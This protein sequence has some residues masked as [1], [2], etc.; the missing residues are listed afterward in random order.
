[1]NGINK[2]IIQ[3]IRPY[4]DSRLLIIGILGF[5]CGTPLLLTSSTLA[6][7]LKEF[8]LTNATIGLFGFL[9]LP[10]SLR[11]IWA[12]L[13]DRMPIPYLTKRFGRRR[14]W[15]LA[16]QTVL[17]L[18]LTGFTQVDIK[19]QLF[20]TSIL[21]MILS[22][23]S[24]THWTVMIA[25]QV[26]SFKRKQY[27]PAEGVNIL[28]YRMGMV[29]SSAGALYLAQIVSWEFA[30]GTM[31][32]CIAL[33]FITT[34]IIDEPI[35]IKNDQAL[36]QEKKINSYLLKHRK[37]NPKFC[38]MLSWIYAA[39]IC[40]FLNFTK[41]PNWLLLLTLMFLYKFG[42][43]LIGSMS[44]LFYMELGFSKIDI[45]NAAKLFGM[46]ASIFG[47]LIGGALIIRWGFMKSIYINAI[48]HMFATLLYIALA[49]AGNDMFMLYLSI[50]IEHIT[51][52]MRTTALLSFQLTLCTPTYAATQLALMTSF[53]SL[54]R[55]LFS[56]ISG[57]LAT[58]LGWV[59]FFIL[60][61][62]ASIPA[63]L[64]VR[65]LMKENKKQN[66]NDI[67]ENTKEELAKAA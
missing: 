16:S 20:M 23:A 40:P 36:I 49:Y 32:I 7:W 57:I 24:A 9:S 45:A 55:S 8:G 30:Y 54:G 48:L 44:N 17:M 28:G 19:S 59:N 38:K 6:I 66:I 50:A 15:L 47:G 29:A 27:G 37:H 25:Y 5:T 26:E 65:H 60:A 34:L 13:V 52:G 58:T 18:T 12:P 22:F 61:T 67:E 41:K 63:I 51:S 53:V 31:A 33:G 46:I 39:V 11:F 14:S 21:A 4:L 56:P 35:P 1:M 62:V 3:I 2:G 42:D 64:I 10:Y 43:N